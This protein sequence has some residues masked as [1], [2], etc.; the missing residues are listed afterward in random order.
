VTVVTGDAPTAKVVLAWDLP[1]RPRLEQLLGA[2]EVVLFLPPQAERWAAVSLRDRRPLPLPG[3]V[4]GARD[5][6]ARRR[7]Q[8]N[9]LLSAGLP[10]E[11]LLALA[12]LF[13]RYDATLIAA[14]L[15]Q[16]AKTNASAAPHAPSAPAAPVATGTM[17]VSAGSMDGVQPKDIVGALVNEIKVDRATIGKVDVREK[18]TLVEL[19]AADVQRVA[20]A[21]TG[22]TIRRKR[23]LARPERPRESRPARGGSDRPSRGPRTERPPRR[24]D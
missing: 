7:T 6:A 2:G 19:P 13:E 22:T 15:Y 10:T 18:F 17:W 11:G 21:F 8:V 20:E 3:A 1:S 16:L 9:D 14:A 12:P 24:R 4:D 5:D 23:V